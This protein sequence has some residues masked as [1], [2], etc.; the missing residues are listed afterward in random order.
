MFTLIELLVVIAIIAI[1]AS[2]LLPALGRAKMQAK[3]I[4]CA[5]LHKQAFLALSMYADDYTEYPSVMSI[6]HKATYSNS[7]RVT[8][9]DAKGEFAMELLDALGYTTADGTQCNEDAS[10]AGGN[11]YGWYRS[12][13]WFQYNGPATNGWAVNH[14]GHTSVMNRLGKHD[15]TVDWPRSTW[16]VDYRFS[17]YGQERSGGKWTT[18]QIAI[19]GCP[20]ILHNVPDPGKIMYEPHMEHPISAITGIVWAAGSNPGT[21][22]RRNY[23]FADGHVKFVRHDGDPSATWLPE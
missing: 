11:A 20:G 1:L 12:K 8:G 3:A 13:A 10:S 9:D 21:R 14:G 23:T 15:W 22:I 18:T 5:S 2:M 6:S 4:V 7:N 17:N 16:G 19:L